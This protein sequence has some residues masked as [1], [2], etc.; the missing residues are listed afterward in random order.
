MNT[1]ESANFS[2]SRSL[3]LKFIRH[4][5]TQTLQTEPS[6]DEKY[7]SHLKGSSCLNC[8]SIFV[9]LSRGI[10]EREEKDLI[11]SPGVLY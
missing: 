3:A 5:G 2:L 6:D 9:K 4:Q 1:T 11:P 8:N 10:G 7:F